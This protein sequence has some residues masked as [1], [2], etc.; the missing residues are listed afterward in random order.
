MIAFSSDHVGF[1]LV[2][3]RLPVDRESVLRSGVAVLTDA[4]SDWDMMY[5]LLSVWCWVMKV[6]GVDERFGWLEMTWWCCAVGF[7]YQL[8]KDTVKHLSYEDAGTNSPIVEMMFP[9]IDLDVRRSCLGRTFYTSEG[10]SEMKLHCE[11]SL[12]NRN[13]TCITSFLW[14]HWGVCWL[15][16]NWGSARSAWYI[17]NIIN[18]ILH[19]PFFI[20]TWPRDITFILV[21]WPRDVFD[22]FIHCIEVRVPHSLSS[23]VIVNLFHF[24]YVLG[25]RWLITRRLW[26]RIHTTKRHWPYRFTTE[27]SHHISNAYLYDSIIIRK[28]GTTGL[29]V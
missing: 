27:F 7:D 10:W 15:C 17:C 3:S 24:I 4:S 25:V 1:C 23:F 13:I 2:F 29:K 18:I 11:F 8:R 14:H 28:T 26:W 16:L 20:I 21:N 19:I 12:L 9:S 22:W 5:G 6:G